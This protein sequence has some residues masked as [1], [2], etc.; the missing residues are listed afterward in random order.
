MV[1][2]NIK[3]KRRETILYLIVGGFICLFLLF[4]IYNN[5]ETI[6]KLTKN[7][8]EAEQEEARQN[9]LY[10]KYV[11]YTEA[12]MNRRATVLPFDESTSL[13]KNNIDIVSRVLGRVANASGLRM[14]KII[15]DYGSIENEMGFL[16]ITVVL[17]G[18][19]GALRVFMVDVGKI[20]YVENVDSLVIESIGLSKRISLGLLV[21]INRQS[22]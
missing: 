15:P 22:L 2:L 4:V 6:S 3:A 13:D 17:E 7:I 20:K 5:N 16:A 1:N 18:H 12:L 8:H 14:I 19:L 11:E 9:L 21:S 10:P